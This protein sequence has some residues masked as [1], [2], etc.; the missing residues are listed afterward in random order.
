MLATGREDPG[1]DLESALDGIDK[2]LT[3]LIKSLK[4]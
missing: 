2:M 3:G 1:K 4:R